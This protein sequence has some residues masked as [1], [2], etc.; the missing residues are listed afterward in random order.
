MK[1]I[2]QLSGLILLF[3]VVSACEE[4]LELLP[5]DSLTP[6]EFYS[7]TDNF[8][9]ALNGVYD[10][11]QPDQFFGN[12]ALLDGITDNGI[13]VNFN[14]DFVEFATG[15]I[16]ASTNNVIT[17]YYQLPYIVIQRANALLENINIE[18]SITPDERRAIEGEARALRAIAYMRL[19]YLFGDVPLITSPLTR[20]EVLEVSRSSRGQI[21]D[22]ILDEFETA[23]DLLE[24]NGFG[25]DT[26]RLTKQAAQTFRGKVLLYEARLGNKT[27]EEA[28]SAISEALTTA[29]SA[30][31][32]LVVVGDGT[33]G[34]ANYQAIF[35]QSNEDNEEIIFA[36]KYDELDRSTNFFEHYG[37]LAGTLY[38]SVH[39]NLVDDYYTN[40]GL[41]I[42]DANSVFDSNDPF[43]NRDPRFYAT[44]IFEGSLYTTGGSLE[45]FVPGVSNPLNRTPYML[46]KFVS[47]EGQAAFNDGR[48]DVIVLRL[49]DLLLMYAEAE[50]EVNGPT[51]EAY[52]AIN[53]VRARVNMP[54]ITS[55]LS[56]E[57]FQAEVLHERR[58]ELAFEEQRWFDLITLGI[59][60][61]RIN[62]IKEDLGRTFIVNKQELFPIPQTEIDL[63]TNLSQN[64]G[65]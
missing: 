43:A 9:A 40:D 49:A 7:N 32:Q 1:N 5:N 22:F 4:D 6:E 41:P 63:N 8:G 39:S 14:T 28:R 21:I 26:G 12:T 33:D 24:T 36:I 44:I 37:V 34:E 56:K 60:D 17:N 52:D 29:Q 23:A 53:Q 31:H 20:N 48:L 59:A 54:A 25:G 35:N 13:A 18:G 46:K 16:S 50:N 51:S 38:M 3:L 47:L 11:V 27:W 19:V 64:P 58:I 55:G 42:S 61:E 15:T 30:G 2:I 65:Y 57:A 45:P 10:A 62:G